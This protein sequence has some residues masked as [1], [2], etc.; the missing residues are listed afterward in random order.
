M[1][2]LASIFIA[3][4]MLQMPNTAFSQQ[5]AQTEG[6]AQAKDVVHPEPAQRINRADSPNNQ[7]QTSPNQASPNNGAINQPDPNGENQ[8][9][10]PNR[11]ET[12]PPP[13]PQV[14][15]PAQP[16]TLSA[17]IKENGTVVPDGLI[18]RV[19]DTKTDE[20]GE[21]ALL[22]RS[23]EASPSL[24]LPPGEY[25]VH[26]S[27]GRAQSSDALSVVLGQNFKT[28]VLD[29]GALR[30]KSAVTTQIEILPE[31]LKFDVY[32]EG[33]EGGQVPV[34]LNIEQNELVYLN[35]GIYQVVSRWG[36]QNAIVR[37]DIRVEPGQI[38]EATLFHNA[39]QVSLSL[40]SSAG[41]EAIADV[42]WQVQ[43]QAGETIYTH[44][45]AFPSAVLAEGEYMV[46]AQSGDQVYNRPFQVQ[47]GRPIKIEVLTSV[48]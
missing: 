20:T 37:A 15:Q 26:A 3:L 41:G 21:L 39:A 32:A 9:I 5:S 27:Y 42:D 1:K 38:T 10:T 46:F 45:G 34:V 7:N 44:L 43:N 25:V 17:V 33:S 16:I 48:Y 13:T 47:A 28:I 4:V 24:S 6:V 36:E 12:T 22:F 11:Q 2:L 29:A 18:W 19:F 31:Q 40:V 35:A 8:N 14:S 30:L 23:E